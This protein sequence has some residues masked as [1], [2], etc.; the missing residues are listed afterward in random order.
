MTGG[1]VS[2]GRG[3]PEP[4]GAA[5]NGSEARGKSG[6]PGGWRWWIAGGVALVVALVIVG[7]V[8]RGGGSRPA[9][10]PAPKGVQSFTESDRNHVNGR[11]LYDR[12]YPGEGFAHR[13]IR[14]SCP[15]RG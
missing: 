3:R 15:I 12:T 4:S 5:R 2:G 14:L 10:G 1:A 7:L 13:Q 8:T 9:S 11:V 6:S